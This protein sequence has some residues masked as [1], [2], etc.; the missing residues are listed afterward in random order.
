MILANPCS[1]I[2]DLDPSTIEVLVT[3]ASRSQA[4]A[5]KDLFYKHLTRKTAIGVTIPVSTSGSIVNS[6]MPC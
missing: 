1:F 3:T 4:P 2:T 6:L 5:L